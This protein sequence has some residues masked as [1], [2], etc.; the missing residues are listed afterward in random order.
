[1]DHA[2]GKK[3]HITQKDGLE[4]CWLGDS[5]EVLGGAGAHREGVEAQTD[6]PKAEF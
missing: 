1:M 5:G 3:P 6:A 2:C 4:S